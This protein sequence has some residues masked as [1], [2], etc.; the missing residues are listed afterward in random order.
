MNKPHVLCTYRLSSQRT[1]SGGSQALC[2]LHARTEACQQVIGRVS[3]RLILKVPHAWSPSAMAALLSA[4]LLMPR[5]H[6]AALSLYAAGCGRRR[7][8]A[9]PQS[10]AGTGRSASAVW[11]AV[12]RLEIRMARMPL[13]TTTVFAVSAGFVCKR[14]AWEVAVREIPKIVMAVSAGFGLVM[15]DQGRV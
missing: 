2:I 1:I 4:K 11:C 5:I 7:G 15:L 3:V 9:P 6:A 13:A 8:P 10:A 14:R 12:L